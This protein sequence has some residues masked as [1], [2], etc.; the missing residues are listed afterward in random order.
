MAKSTWTFRYPP[1]N[2]QLYISRETM[3]LEKKL[4]ES[5]CAGAGI[6]P[7]GKPI[8]LLMSFCKNTS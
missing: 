4:Q 5:I 7:F 2:F 1:D 8:L 6:Q 3:K